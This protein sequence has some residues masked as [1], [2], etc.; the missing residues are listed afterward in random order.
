VG[1]S[2]LQTVVQALSKLGSLNGL[3]TRFAQDLDRVILAPAL[4]RILDDKHPT[5]LFEKD[6]IYLSG[7]S[8]DANAQ[9][10]L[11][12][13]QS[14]GEWLSAR[15]PSS[16]LTPLAGELMPTIA[17]RLIVNWLN[18]TAPRSLKSIPQFQEI[19]AQVSGL[20]SFFDKLGWTGQQALRDWVS[21]APDVWLASQKTSVAIKV[22]NL[23]S[24]RI[25]ERHVVERVETQM[26]ARND[27][28][29]PNSN[30]EDENWGAD[31]G[32]EQET[33]EE[34]EKSDP[35]DTAKEGIE[36]EDF[37]AWGMDD[38]DGPNEE[39]QQDPDRPEAKQGDPKQEEEEIDTDAWDWQ[40]DEDTKEEPAAEPGKH[41]DTQGSHTA[42]P[43]TRSEP[44]EQEVSLRE[45][46]TVTGIPDALMDI[47]AQVVADVETLNQPRYEKTAIAP[48]SSSLYDIPQEVLT[49]YRATSGAYYSKEIAD[50]ML[51]YNDCMRLSDR[52]RSYTSE[53]AQKDI[54]S[55]LPQYLK[56]SIRMD[57]QDDIKMIEAFGRRAYA[58]EMESQRTIIRDLLDG[59]QGFQSSTTPPFAM[60]CDNAITMTIDRVYEVKRQW[61]DVLSRS[62]LLQSLGSLISTALAKFIT[63]I[64]DLSD[65]SEK[66][67]Q[68]LRYYCEQLSTLNKLFTTT[69]ANGEPKDETSIYTPNW[70]RFQY[71][72]EILDGT[73]ADIRYMWSEGELKLEMGADEVIDLVKALFSDSEHRRKTISTIRRTSLN[74]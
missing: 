41:P 50:D 18:D 58:K 23:F 44:A 9:Y 11:R 51:I 10:I 5:V 30:E 67:S 39:V 6:R 4:G 71:L 48:A 54:S 31:W 1:S 37:S 63:D 8:S 22:R 72:S 68:K 73:L 26:V 7:A 47:I 53:L 60:E 20:A 25:N 61:E 64:E 2:S 49:V 40:D 57:V 3:I 17:H 13:V 24:K 16:I 62:A 29:A 19:L 12:F 28:P 65:I 14:L 43:A 74:V 27:I 15:L 45:A 66:E 34:P 69:D 56:P 38:E 21:Q 33:S 59:A 52:L 32:D 36:E 42:D 55:S 35:S 70:F 46:Y